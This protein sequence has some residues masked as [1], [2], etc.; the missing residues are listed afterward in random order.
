MQTSEGFAMPPRTPLP[1]NASSGFDNADDYVESLLSFITSEDL[2]HKLC[3]GVHILD[4]LTKEPDLYSSLLPQEWRTWFQCHDVSDVLDLL[5]RKDSFEIESM[6]NLDGSKLPSRPD[7]NTSEEIAS[8]PPVDLLDYILS[9]RKHA[10]CRNFPKSTLPQDYKAQT[11]SHRLPRHVSVGMKPKKIHEVE[12]FAK[13]IDSLQADIDKSGFQTISHV[14]DFGSGQNYLGRA[15][16]SPPYRRN[17]IALESKQHNIDGAKAMDVIARLAEKEKIMRN[18]KK[19]RQGLSNQL[20]ELPVVGQENQSMLF[21]PSDCKCLNGTPNSSSEHGSIQYIE[22]YIEDGDLSRVVLQLKS[23]TDIAEEPDPRLMIVSLHSC[24]NL[25]HH[26]L[27]S[28]VLNSAV[29]IVAMVGCCYN[30]VT[31]RLGPP[32]YKLPSLRSSNLRLDQTSSASDP[33]GFPM[34][35][36][37]ASYKH[38]HGYGIRLNITARMMAVQAPYNWTATDCSSFFTRHFYRAL[39]QRILLDHGIVGEPT[40]DDGQESSPRGWTGA[41]PALCIGS[42]RK[43]CYT[44]FTAYVRG[45]LSKLSDDP[46]YGIQISKTIDDITNEEIE[47]YEKRYQ[48]KKKELSIV[49]S[50]MAFSASVVESVMVVDRWLYL[51]EQEK[52]KD[53]WVETVFDYKQSPRNLVVVGIKK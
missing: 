49:W 29:K 11:A 41:G 23:S 28:F 12:N 35:E 14:V 47:T 7:H 8:R 3:G 46:H 15:F 38:Q 25:L 17:V 45:A 48:A 43:A 24:G 9:I 5:L 18:K 51:R 37:L 44:S 26:G 31:G 4:F 27:R 2:F 33:H 34:S 32:T 22:T 13:Y 36:R 20:Q 50:L 21:P 10:L 53:C 40:Y 39:L 30:L 52:V 16:A 6:K 1:L 19:H 42:L